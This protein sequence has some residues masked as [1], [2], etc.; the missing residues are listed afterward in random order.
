M[1][2]AIFART[3]AFATAAGVLDA[4]VT[5]GYAG[6]QFNLSCI[7]LE[8]LPPS[9]PD[10]AAEAVAVEAAR[11]GLRIAA[12]S[13]TYNMAHPDS[14]V[15]LASRPRFANV[16][17]A[18]RRMGARIVTLCTGT[19]NAGDIWAGHPDNGS[20]AA[21]RDFRHELDFA[22]DLASAAGIKLAVEPEPGNVI[23]DAP[24]ARRLL[25]EVG[26]DNLGIILDAANL[27]TPEVLE[28]QHQ[29]MAQA[30]DLLG[31]DILLAHAKDISARGRVVAPGDGAVNMAAFVGLLRKAGFDGALV[32][33]GFDQTDA[34]MAAQRLKSLIAAA[35]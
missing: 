8:P 15:R 25:D 22:L 23:A 32:A 28:R 9:L 27:L 1:Y 19:R 14:A 26:A 10:G 34:A 2:P 20:A 24:A 35:P 11:R 3:Y 5:D 13:G 16:V 7:G 4:A 30:A 12:L 18:A 33:H 29:I 17:T 31:G 21:W 6:V